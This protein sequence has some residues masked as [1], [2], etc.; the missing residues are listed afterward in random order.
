[1]ADVFVK[2][3]VSLSLESGPLGMKISSLFGTLYYLEMF[4]FIP[5]IKLSGRISGVAFSISFSIA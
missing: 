1:M 4:E 2:E 5:S 3:L